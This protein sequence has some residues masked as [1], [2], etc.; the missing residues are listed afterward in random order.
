[1]T[2]YT[3]EIENKTPEEI[4]EQANSL[5]SVAKDISSRLMYADHG[6]YGQDKD[7]IRDLHRKADRLDWHAN[8][9]EAEID[10]DCPGNV[11]NDQY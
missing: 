10:L 3:K 8:Q 9:I 11:R 1:M 6:A 4:R 2:V 7:R 5:R